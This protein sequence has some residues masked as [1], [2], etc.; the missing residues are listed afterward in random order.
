M[1]VALLLAVPAVIELNHFIEK[2]ALAV[3]ET[4]VE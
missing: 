2:I 4:E 1:K 3:T